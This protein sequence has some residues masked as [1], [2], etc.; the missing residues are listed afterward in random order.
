M[1]MV[2]LLIKM[3]LKTTT[4]A[5]TVATIATCVSANCIGVP[6]FSIPGIMTIGPAWCS[7]D[8]TKSV[9][10]ACKPDGGGLQLR[11]G[12]SAFTSK[13]AGIC[14]INLES[15]E[16]QSCP[17]KADA[18]FFGLVN[19]NGPLPPSMR[20]ATVTVQSIDGAKRVSASISIAASGSYFPPKISTF[21]RGHT[22]R[23][24]INKS[25]DLPYFECSTV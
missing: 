12:V 5:L 17:Q 22:K 11:I 24:D 6:G 16:P 9:K 21:G 10:D 7:K 14:D 13:F 2:D 19:P 15:S 18:G 3:V 25:V 1:I 23:W 20:F 4:V 8:P